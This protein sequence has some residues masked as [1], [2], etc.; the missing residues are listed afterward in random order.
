[1]QRLVVVRLHPKVPLDAALPVHGRARRLVAAEWSP[2][3]LE[4]LARGLARNGVEAEVEAG[5][6]RLLVGRADFRAI[7]DRVF[8]GLLPT[9]E[10]GWPVAAHV[11]SAAGGTLHAHENC[12]DQEE[13]ATGEKVR[14]GLAALRHDLC[15][16]VVHIEVVKSF[17]PRVHHIVV[18]IRAE[19]S[20]VDTV[21][22]TP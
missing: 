20:L 5:D 12:R 10:P 16:R 11:L 2:A 17:A 21:V 1:M 3:A 19:A 22:D 4:G 15:F 13:A 14:A 18:D 6:N 8:L 9:S 7:A